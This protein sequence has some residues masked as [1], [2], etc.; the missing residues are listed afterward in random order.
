MTTFPLFLDDW[1]R[2]DH[3]VLI[4]RRSDAR[5]WLRQHGRDVRYRPSPEIPAFLRRRPRVR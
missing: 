4:E 2:R 3:D 5:I 1:H